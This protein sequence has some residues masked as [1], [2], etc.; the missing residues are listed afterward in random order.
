VK[1]SFLCLVFLIVLLVCQFTVLEFVPTV[2]AQESGGSFGNPTI[3]EVALINWTHFWHLFNNHSA[4]DLEYNN[5]SGWKS[6][7]SDLQVIKS[8]R[9]WM[10]GH[11]ET[12]N[13][14]EATN[15][16]I[17][18]NFT[19][20]YNASY[21][22]TFGID[23]DVKNYTHKEGSWNYTI[24]YQNYTVCFD[25]SDI[26]DLPLDYIGH[27]VK[28]VDEERWFWFRI[29]KDDVKKGTN[30]VIDPTFGYETFGTTYSTSIENWIVG[31]AFTITEDGTANSISL[32]LKSSTSWTGNVKCAIYQGSDHTYVGETEEKQ[33]TVTTTPTWFTFNF[34]TQP[35]LSANTAYV[36]VGWGQSLT[37]TVYLC[38]DGGE[39]NQGHTQSITYNDF[40][41]TA[42]FTHYA[43]KYSVYCTYTAAGDTTS[44][45]YSNVG[46]NTT[47]AGQPCLFYTK[48]TDETGLATTGG[49]IFGTNN[50][51]TWTNDTWTAFTAN[52]DWSNV[53]KTLNSTIGVRVEWRIWANDTSNN[54]NNTGIQFLITITAA[55]N[56]YGSASLTYAVNIL[57]TVRFNR[58]GTSTLTFISTAT[59][60]KRQLLS[61]LGS[62]VLTFVTSIS[63]TFTFSAYGTS[64]LTFTIG[65]VKTLS[66]NRYGTSALTFLVESF[67]NIVSTTFLTFHGS[68][69]LTFITNLMR[70]WSLNR[71]GTASLA[72]TIETIT[73]F[74]SSKILTLYGS[75]TLNFLTEILKTF[76]LTRYATAPLTFTIRHW[77][78]LI[79]PA[80]PIN[81]GL[82]AIGFAMIAFAVAVTALLTKRKGEE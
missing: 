42:S 32:G 11:W 79:A 64:T 21:R 24:T 26:K 34:I 3:P 33:I 57:K 66:F 56:F 37:G 4:W 15:C 30:V 46:T 61:F 58:Y 82:V 6:I 80:A 1:R 29:R 74:V 7:K 53:T 45:T 31:S 14:T 70:T 63:K 20:S 59:F 41:A 60:S 18:L 62:A 68:A 38:G 2:K 36:L 72:F 12:V 75:A 50:T 17:T 52:P 23:L 67:Q 43:I 48:W 19:A 47:Q 44:P 27:G 71:Y 81:Y 22:L 78:S 39:T 40:P 49:F 65:T 35:N 9:V 54:W 25:W 5:G 28:L 13:K 76:T 51:G 10:D 77:T 73:N 8:Y 69:E 55:Y 16:K